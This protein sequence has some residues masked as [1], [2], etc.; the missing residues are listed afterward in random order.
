MIRA[1]VAM[2]VMRE[3]VFKKAVELADKNGELASSILLGREL[4]VS[5]SV[6]HAHLQDLEDQGRMLRIGSGS[7]TR[8]MPV[9]PKE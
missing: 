8:Y 5:Q 4:G 2:S 9:L 7:Y 3:R 1:P 6:A